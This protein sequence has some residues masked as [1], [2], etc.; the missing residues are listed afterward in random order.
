MS[1]Q[2][3]IGTNGM[4]VWRSKDLGDTITRGSI[5]YKVRVVQP[6]DPGGFTVLELRKP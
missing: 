6:E 1:P 3:Y 2:L 4:S 5:I